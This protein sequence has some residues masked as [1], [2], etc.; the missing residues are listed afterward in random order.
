MKIAATCLVVVLACA[1]A[2]AQVASDPMEKFRNC[3]P[4][5]LA[6]RLECLEK[7]SREMAPPSSAYP[8]ES[9]GGGG[10]AADVWIV[11]ETTSP[12]DYSPVAVATAWS[13]TGPDGVSLQVSIQC[14][15]GRSELVMGGPT[16]ARR[17]DDFVVSYGVND[18]PSMVLGVATPAPGSGAAVKADVVRLLMSLPDQ[19]HIA[20]RLTTRQGAAGE[21]RYDLARLRAV[22]NRMAVPCRWPAVARAPRK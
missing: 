1:D 15:G 9:P 4:L 5:V 22:V 3:V 21:G 12:L 7:L 2:A 17:S 8:V 14:R 19:G 6:E 18:G 10:S 13:G 11:S 20:F 16:V